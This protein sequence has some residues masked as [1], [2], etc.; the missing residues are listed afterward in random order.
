MNEMKMFHASRAAS[1]SCKNVENVLS[2]KLQLQIWNSSTYLWWRELNFWYDRLNCVLEFFPNGRC[3]HNSLII[4]HRTDTTDS[5]NNILKK[6]DFFCKTFDILT[7]SGWLFCMSS[8]SSDM[9]EV[10]RP[11][12]SWNLAWSILRLHEPFRRET[13]SGSWKSFN[14]EDYHGALVQK[15]Q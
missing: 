12:I 15:L 9:K 13:F 2:L 6:T 5:H 7:L 1:R 14:L 4:M 10:I 3:E 11:P 8:S